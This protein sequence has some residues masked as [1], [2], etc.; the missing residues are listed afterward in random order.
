MSAVNATGS[1]FPML[2]RMWLRG[3]LDCLEND[4]KV[5]LRSLSLKCYLAFAIEDALPYTF[6]VVESGTL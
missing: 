5:L 6:V 3:C 2:E 4:L 1:M